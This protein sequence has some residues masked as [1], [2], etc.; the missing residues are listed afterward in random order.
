MHEFRGPDADGAFVVRFPNIQRG[1]RIKSGGLTQANVLTLVNLA[2]QPNSPEEPTD[3]MISAAWT[4]TPDGISYL[5]FAQLY[6]EVWAL[7][8]RAAQEEQK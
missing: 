7:A 5:A 1:V 4:Y 8:F 2:K 3:E 6:K